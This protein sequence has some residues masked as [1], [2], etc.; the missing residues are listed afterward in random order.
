VSIGTRNLANVLL[1]LALVPVAAGA[2]VIELRTF[3][4]ETDPR[5]R[6][7]SVV[8]INAGPNEIAAWKGYDGARNRL[9]SRRGAFP[10]ALAPPTPVQPTPVRIPPGEAATLYTLSMDAVF[11]LRLDIV[12]LGWRWSWHPP[13]PRGAPPQSPF[14]G[15]NALGWEVRREP[16]AEFVAVAEVGGVEAR[17]NPVDIHIA[18]PQVETVKLRARFT[19]AIESSRAGV[20]YYEMNFQSLDVALT[21]GE[22]R[23]RLEAGFAEPLMSA[24]GAKL[25]ASRQRYKFAAAPIVLTFS[26]L[27]P[28]ERDAGRLVLTD[29]DPR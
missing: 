26:R 15:H 7:I 11:Y 16:S 12:N 5:S 27:G 19:T 18:P 4:S 6:G 25:D 21:T 20:R 13:A 2:P 22:R 3:A 28:S 9:T 1:W 8:V 10:I 23:L 14:H 24:A 29:Y 17:S